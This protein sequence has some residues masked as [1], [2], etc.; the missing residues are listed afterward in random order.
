MGAV[1]HSSGSGQVAEGKKNE[2]IATIVGLSPRAVQK[3][4]G[5]ILRTLGVKTQ[6]AAAARALAATAQ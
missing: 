5:N 6:T 3:H 2:E 1:V 4:V